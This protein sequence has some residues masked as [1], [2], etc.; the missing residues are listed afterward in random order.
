M[1][2]LAVL[3]FGQPRPKAR[4]ADDLWDEET[5]TPPDHP[6]APERI[7]IDAAP[8]LEEGCLLHRVQTRDGIEWWLMDQDGKLAEVLLLE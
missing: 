8:W 5:P 7:R 2:K 4:P 1:N 6:L 3:L